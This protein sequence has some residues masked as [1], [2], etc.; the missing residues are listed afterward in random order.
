VRVVRWK[1]A[2]RDLFRRLGMN[3][4]MSPDRIYISLA[5]AIC[6]ASEF[7]DSNSLTPACSVTPSPAGRPILPPSSALPTLHLTPAAAA[8]VV[9]SAADDESRER[10]LKSGGCSSG[11]GSGEDR[12]DRQMEPRSN[13]GPW[14][15][16]A[17]T[18]AA[19]IAPFSSVL[20]RRA[21][22]DRPSNQAADT[23]RNGLL[24]SDVLASQAAQDIRLSI[25]EPAKGTD[26]H[27]TVSAEGAAVGLSSAESSA[28]ADRHPDSYKPPSP[29]RRASVTAASIATAA[30]SAVASVAPA[31]LLLVPPHPASPRD[32]S[33]WGDDEAHVEY[34]R[35]DERAGP[36]DR[37]RPSAAQESPPWTGHVWG[38]EASGEA[39]SPALSSRRR[40][41]T[42][43][44]EALTRARARPSG[45][46][47]PPRVR[48]GVADEGRRLRREG[49]DWR[50]GKEAEEAMW[51]RRNEAR[52][53]LELSAAAQLMTEVMDHDHPPASATSRGSRR[54]LTSRSPSR[55]NMGGRHGFVL[56]W[57][58]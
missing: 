50:K 6:D 53:P 42:S 15:A 30:A 11:E 40:C 44:V 4:V 48:V 16:A 23:S 34:G 3:E 8:A 27:S 26:T 14:R 38:G 17:A 54:S 35:A 32:D 51:R 47:S 5:D 55:H 33:L 46:P 13:R 24:A 43:E 9:V 7:L 21:V 29:L 36:A 49:R 2:S 19:A 45:Y 12:G 28:A 25:Q 58:I 22:G 41:S 52:E 37:M 39:S 18:V 1:G 57:V 31:A 56:D 20:R 10:T